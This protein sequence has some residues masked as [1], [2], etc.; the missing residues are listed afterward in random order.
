VLD[1]SNPR[2]AACTV[3]LLAR[4]V[5]ALVESAGAR[6]APAGEGLLDGKLGVSLAQL[7]VRDHDA[8]WIRLVALATQLRGWAFD[9]SDWI[10]LHY[11]AHAD[12]PLRSMLA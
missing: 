12:A 5:A 3:Q 8:R 10:D 1:S 11:F 4:E 6:P 2:S 7:R 9:L